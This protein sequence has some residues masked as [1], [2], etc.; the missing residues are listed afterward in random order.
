MSHGGGH[1]AIF[2][3]ISSVE[4]Q[5]F[6]FLRELLSAGQKVVAGV[7]RGELEISER[8]GNG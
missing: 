4:P 7:R 3:L 5:N 2:T 1:C 8:I 6:P